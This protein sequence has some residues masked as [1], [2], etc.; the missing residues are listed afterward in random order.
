MII[1]FTGPNGYEIQQELNR[2]KHDFIDKHDANGLEKHN[3]TDLE[4]NQLSD[5]LRGGSLFSSFRFIVIEDISLNKELAEALVSQ[6]KNVP[7]EIT[8]ILIDQKPDKRTGW[9]KQIQKLGDVRI[10]NELSSYE[11][12]RWVHDYVKQHAGTIKQ[13]DMTFLIERVGYNQR[14]LSSEL[15]KLL[16]KD[17]TI[18]TESI[19]S[20]VEPNPRESIFQLLDAVVRGDTKLAHRLYVELRQKDV[21]AFQFV[22]ML[23]WQLHNMLL[24]KTNIG[25]SKL[26]LAQQASISPY[27]IDKTHALVKKISLKQIKQSIELVVEADFQIKQTHV[28]VDRRAMLLI[29][30]ITRS[31]IS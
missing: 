8:L 7:A 18:S 3:A 30:K 23:A 9:Y 14:L 28:D 5:L 31:I 29:D 11:I 13:S 27:V 12:N 20:L 2:L 15:D 26:D 16:I 4:P 24:V 17:K 22:S 19:E 10:K 25:I 1:L 21:D 6:L